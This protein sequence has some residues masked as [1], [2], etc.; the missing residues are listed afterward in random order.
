MHMKHPD[1]R[2]RALAALLALVFL[3]PSHG[4]ADAPDKASSQTILTLSGKV[5]EGR[6]PLYWSLQDVQRL[7]QHSFTTG[8]PWSTGAHTYSGPLLRDLLQSAGARGGTLNAAALNDYKI[9]IPVED[10]VKFDV[11][12]AHSID[13]KPMAIRDKGPLFI[14]YP[15]DLRP[16]LR[17][18][19]Y[20]RRAIWQ[21]KSIEVE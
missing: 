1:A 3:V 20:Y 6:G 4:R 12:V 10:A 21:L 7:P 5:N 9:A 13:G 19:P 16:E 8:T 18:S 11:I 14:V 2:R 15:F 17:G